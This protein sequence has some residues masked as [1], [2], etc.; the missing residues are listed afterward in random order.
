MRTH[1]LSRNHHDAPQAHDRG[2]SR[3]RGRA[4]RETQP[5][6]QIPAIRSLSLGRAPS[7]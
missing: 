5:S 6:M 1:P 2:R 3:D 7:C 4:S